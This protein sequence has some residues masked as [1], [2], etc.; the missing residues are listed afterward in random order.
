MLSS[1]ST[2]AAHGHT[3]E[4][5][6]TERPDQYTEYVGVSSLLHGGVPSHQ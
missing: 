1:V 5:T 2:Q 3:H 4:L 6:D